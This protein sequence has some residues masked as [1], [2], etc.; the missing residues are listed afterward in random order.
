MT[1]SYLPYLPDQAHLLPVSASDWLPDGHLAYFIADAMTSLD[2]SAFHARYAKGGP[3]NQP[4]NPE[5]MVKVLLYGYATGVFF[6]AP[7]ARHSCDGRN[8]GLRVR[9]NQEH[10]TTRTAHLFSKSSR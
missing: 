5:M 9:A 2:L 10:S 8:D 3:R 4:F 7:S 1:T 6:F